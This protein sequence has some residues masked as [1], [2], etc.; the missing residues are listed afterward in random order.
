MATDGDGDETALDFSLVVEQDNRPDFGSS[1]IPD[2]IFAMNTAV[3]VMLPEADGG[4]GERI[5]SL[6]PVLPPGLTY[7]TGDRTITGTPTEG[8]SATIFT[9]TATD[10]DGDEGTIT[11]SI[12]V[13]PNLA[14]T[15]DAGEDRSVTVLASITLNGSGSDPEGETLTYMWSRLSGVAGSF[16]DTTSATPTFTAADEAGDVVFQLIVTDERGLSSPPNSVTITVNPNLA[17]TADAGEGRIVDIGMTV[18]LDGSG[19]SDPEDQPLT[20]IVGAGSSGRGR[21]NFNR[22]DQPLHRPSPPRIKLERW[23]FS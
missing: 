17:P 4:N 6:S 7:A 16:N 21:V 1:T 5:Y 13:N 9:Y 15:A 14:P 10:Q 2:Q 12:T 22:Y 23:C 18:I 11:F 20:Y 3:E 19:S 8:Y